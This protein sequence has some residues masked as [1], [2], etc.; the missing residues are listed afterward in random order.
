MFASVAR[1]LPSSVRRKLY[2]GRTYLSA[3]APSKRLPAQRFVV[4]GAGRCGST[5]LVELL[6]AHPLIHCDGE[7]LRERKIFP[8]LYVMGRLKSA[9]AKTY[10]FKLLA[11]HI[12]QVQ[13]IEDAHAFLS[14]IHDLGFIIFYLKRDNI[15]RH[16]LSNIHARERV[17]HRR[18][19]EF[20]AKEPIQVSVSLLDSWIQ[21]LEGG[22]RYMEGEVLRDLPR[23]S[24]S[25]ERDLL[26]SEAQ[27]RT[28][29]MICR[30]LSIPPETVTSDLVRATPR[31]TR[32]LVSNFG[33]LLRHYR[34]TPYE[35][36]V[37]DSM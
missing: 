25:Y 34:G 29:G 31:A 15:V 18:R 11:Y 26:D 32:D 30:T 6:G 14:R 33:E 7:I 8:Q 23:V 22:R 2:G 20:A 1:K 28:V 27:Q 35:R 3:L 16:A 17:F 4:F 5:L 9:A 37:N 13:R 21:R 19:S 12:R 10:G 36:F 24:L